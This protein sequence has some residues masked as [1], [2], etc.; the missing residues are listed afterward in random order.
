[1]AAVFGGA[2]AG[3]AG[4]D[5]VLNVALARIG[6]APAEYDRAAAAAVGTHLAGYDVA[7]RRINGIDERVDGGIVGIDRGR[8]ARVE[9]ASFARRDRERPQETLAHEGVRIDQRNQTIGAG[10]L[11]QGRADIRR[12]LGLVG[13]AAEVEMNIVAGLLDDDV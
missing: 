1:G 2:G 7:H 5:L 4:D 6:A 8:E 12:A 10:R 3:A 11:H 9:H 13:R